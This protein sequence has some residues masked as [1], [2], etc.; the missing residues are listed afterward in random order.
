MVKMDRKLTIF[1]VTK[2]VRFQTTFHL[3][4]LSPKYHLMSSTNLMHIAHYQQSTVGRKVKNMKLVYL[5]FH[6]IA[7]MLL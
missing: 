1:S 5:N 2:N 3:S 6:I 4:L 7:S